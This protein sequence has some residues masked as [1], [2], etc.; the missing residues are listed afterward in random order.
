MRISTVFE[1]KSP[2]LSFEIF[3]PKHGG[4]LGSIY[5]TLRCLKALNP[6]F[7]SVTFGAGGSSGGISTCDLAHIIKKDFGIE[8]LVHL[9][10]QGSTQEELSEILDEFKSHGLS[11]I[12]ALRGDKNPDRPQPGDFSY[13]SELITFVKGKWDFDVSA[14]CYPEGHTEAKSLVDDLRHLKEK[15]DA[16]ATHLISQ[17]FFDN[18]MFYSFQEKAAIAGITVPIEA[19]IMPVVNRRQ[20]ER[21]V[22]LCGASLPTKFRRIIERYEHHPEALQDAGIAYAVDQVVDLVAQNVDGIHLYTM[23]NPQIV[24]KICQSIKN[25]ISVQRQKA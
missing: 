5:E 1:K 17:L 19:G 4:D 21:M 13:A 3:P 15:V 9:T 23:N 6:D 2:V 16:G 22:S 20:I 18:D 14:A 10:C 24:E 7:I 12:L 11:N 8:P 25:V